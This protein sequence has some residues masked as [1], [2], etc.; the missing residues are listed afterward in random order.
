[1]SEHILQIV[2]PIT[3]E[4]YTRRQLIAEAEIDIDDEAE[5]RGVIITGPPFWLIQPAAGVP[6]WTAYAPGSVLIARV[7]AEVAADYTA[8]RS[9]RDVNLGKVEAALSGGLTARD[10]NTAERRYVV[11]QLM[12]EGL[13][14]RTIG[15]RLRWSDTPVKARN[16]VMRFR[17]H[18]QMPRTTTRPKALVAA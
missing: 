15:L 7:P 6:G 5:E 2:W 1:M 10:L 16:C 17:T 11:E 18:H 8:W 3:D 9:R 14:D 4:N 12:D 13:D